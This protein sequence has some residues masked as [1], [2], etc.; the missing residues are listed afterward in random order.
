MLEAELARQQDSR[1]AAF[2]ELIEQLLIE[3]P[4]PMGIRIR[5]TRSIRRLN[6]QVTQLTLA[7][8]QAP[9]D[10]PQR[11]GPPQLAEQHG[12]TLAPTGEAAGV[13]LGLGLPHQALEFP[14]GEQLQEL[15]EDATDL[16]H[17]WASWV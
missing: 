5:Q 14:A 8:G 1:A 12:H 10:L 7:G 9:A 3:P 6:P 13:A 4:G 15:A 2:Q 11:M 16:A 17:G